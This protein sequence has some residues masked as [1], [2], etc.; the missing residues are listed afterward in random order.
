M[1]FVLGKIAWIVFKPS[2]LLF[3]GVLIA[4]LLRLFRA[5]ALSRWIG[6]LSLAGLLACAVLPVGAW[7]IGPLEDRFPP[8]ATIARVDGIVVLGGAIQPSLSADRGA[9]A[10]NGNVERLT[11]FADLARKYPAAKLVFTGGSG[12]IDRPDAREGD[13]VG[14]FLDTVGLARAR[15][16]IDRESRNTVENARFTKSLMKPQAGEVWLLVTSA[17]HMPRSIGVFRK[18][19]WQVVPFPADYVTPRN[20]DWSFRFDIAGGLGALDAAAYEWI[21]LVY[22]RLTGRTDAL[23]PG[24]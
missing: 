5:H 18:E 24:P 7:L 15:V 23:F 16:A 21:G 22:Y 2:N 1:S 4:A 12:D 20:T 11:V 13:W 17:R 3:F 10:L 9:L 6:G 14:P 8:P 19:G